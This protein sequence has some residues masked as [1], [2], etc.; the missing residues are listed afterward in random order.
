M[1]HRPILQRNILFLQGPPGPFFWLLAQQLE[2]MGHG[3]FRIN[4]NGGDYGD[5]PGAAVDYRG[6]QRRWPLYVDHFMRDNGITDLMLFGDCRPMHMAAHQM[7]K[8]R[9]VHVHVFEEGY[10]R[11]DWVTLEPSGVNGHSGLPRD[12]T[13]YVDQAQNLPPVPN[14]PSITSSFGRRAHDSYWYYHRMIAARILYPFYQSHR[15]G[16]ALFEG[17]GWLYKFTRA[18]REARATAKALASLGERPYFLL[19]LQLTN[20]YQIKTHSPF[21]SMVEAL[22]Y[23]IASFYRRAPADAVLVVKEHPMEVGFKSWASVIERYRRIY[24]PGH[25]LVH[26]TGGDLDTL[27]RGS[28]GMVTVNSTSATLALQAGVPTVAL[29]AAIYDIPGLTHQGRLDDFWNRPQ[30]PDAT[31]NDAFRRVLHDRCLVYGGFGSKSAVEKLVASTVARLMIQGPAPLQPMD[32]VTSIN[33]PG[34]PKAFATR[35]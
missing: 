20:D 2:A 4:L 16:S 22:E 15:S 31:V 25:R 7:A 34:S 5:W 11:P 24:K 12:P 30:A 26:I 18:K 9:E 17:F 28:R 29:G 27:A 21:A 14:R 35:G 13:W 1:K 8:L 32:V 19:P 23:I 3:V 6:T 33:F 10:I